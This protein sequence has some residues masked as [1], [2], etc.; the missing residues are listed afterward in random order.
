MK[1]KFLFLASLATAL[2]LASEPALAHG[3]RGSRGRGHAYGHRIVRPVVVRPYVPARPY[4]PVRVV[5][6]TPWCHPHGLYHVHY[7][8]AVT[9]YDGGYYDDPSWHFSFGVSW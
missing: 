3:R 4:R 5:P 2:A 8:P 7:E 9:V 1:R 6:A